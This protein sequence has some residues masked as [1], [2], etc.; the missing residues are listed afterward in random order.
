M[1]VTV[2]ETEAGYFITWDMY[3]VNSS[4]ITVMWC[5]RKSARTCENDVQWKVF[6][7]P[8]KGVHLSGIGHEKNKLFAVAVHQENQTSGGLTFPKCYYTLQNSQDNTKLA[9]TAERSD[10]N[11]LAVKLVSLYCQ[12]PSKPVLYQ[13]F[14]Q[15][16]KKGRL[17]CQ[18]VISDLAGNVT[19]SAAYDLHSIMLTNINP[20][21]SYDVCLRVTLANNQTLSSDIQTI[22]SI[23]HAVEKIERGRAG[24]GGAGWNGLVGEGLKGEGLE[25]KGK[26]ERGLEGEGLEGDGMEGEGL[27]GERL[28]GKGFEG[29]EGEGG[30]KQ[31]I[32]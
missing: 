11:R 30:H 23:K 32:N 9:F 13:V 28:E 31:H 22:K 16:H 14:Y 26:K 15:E 3:D 8:G 27:K 2:E 29:V 18:D 25:G 10:S 19:R 1:V 5:T 21:S 20:Q 7:N 12:Y 6:Q 24:G 4:A 17:S